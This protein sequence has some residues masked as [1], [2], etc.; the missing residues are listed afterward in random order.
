ML[1]LEGIVSHHHGAGNQTE[2]L[3][4]GAASALNH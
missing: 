3:S 1:E 4:T 2:D